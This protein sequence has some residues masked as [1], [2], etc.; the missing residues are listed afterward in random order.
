M[1]D[2]IVGGALG[3]FVCNLLFYGIVYKD[4]ARGFWVGIIAAIIFIP[5]TIFIPH[6]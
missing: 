4:W 6:F 5:L 3:M 2:M 1:A